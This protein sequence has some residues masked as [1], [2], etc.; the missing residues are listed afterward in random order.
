M[1]WFGVRDKSG[2]VKVAIT[3]IKVVCNN[4]LN[5]ALSTAKHSF[6]MIRIG[7]MRIRYYDTPDLGDVGKKHNASLMQC[8][9]L[10][11]M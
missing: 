5:L 3:P 4:T 8:L 1:A 2:S 7:D 11:L 6:S 10:L 9:I